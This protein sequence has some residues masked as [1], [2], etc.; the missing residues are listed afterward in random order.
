MT[1]RLSA[2]ILR[3]EDRPAADLI[4]GAW[5]VLLLLG[6]LHLPALVS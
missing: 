5:L 4:G 2:A 3:F 1:R 6:L